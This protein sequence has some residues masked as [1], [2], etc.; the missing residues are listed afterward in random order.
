[1]DVPLRGLYIGPSGS[2]ALNDQR[3]GRGMD[4]ER[5]NSVRLED[6]NSIDSTGVRE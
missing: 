3:V 5:T 1:M 4:G 6:S 2:K